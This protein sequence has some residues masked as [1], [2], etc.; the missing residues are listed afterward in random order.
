MTPAA[1]RHRS[2]V[3]IERVAADR[4]QTIFNHAVD[5]RRK[6]LSIRGPCR[7]VITNHGPEVVVV[8]VPNGDGYMA[9]WVVPSVSFDGQLPPDLRQTATTGRAVLDRYYFDLTA[10]GDYSVSLRAD[11]LFSSLDTFEKEYA[12]PKNA[13]VKN[14]QDYKRRRREILLACRAQAEIPGFPQGTVRAYMPDPPDIVIT[15]TTSSA[16]NDSIDESRPGDVGIEVSELIDQRQHETFLHAR[17]AVDE[18]VELWLRKADPNADTG[19]RLDCRAPARAATRRVRGCPV[20][21]TVPVGPPPA[22]FAGLRPRRATT[23]RRAGSPNAARCAGARRA[24]VRPAGST[25]RKR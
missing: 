21:P 22:R 1:L 11:N 16:S 20:P 19:I 17:A 9:H 15:P 23:R 8:D 18:A 6:T 4:T 25:W 12:G 13:A 7:V 3:G 5:V 2:R 10:P 14:E 24:R